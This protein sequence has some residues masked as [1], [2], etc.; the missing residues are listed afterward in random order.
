MEVLSDKDDDRE[1]Y[2][3]KFVNGIN[4]IEGSDQFMCVFKF[5]PNDNL[6]D[7]SYRYHQRVYHDPNSEEVMMLNVKDTDVKMSTFV[8]CEDNCTKILVQLDYRYLLFNSDG[9]FQ[10]P[11]L[12]DDLQ[13]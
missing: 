2:E 4:V 1:N 6:K 9:I 3:K 5:I 7:E 11:V 8:K 12:F 10:G 13:L